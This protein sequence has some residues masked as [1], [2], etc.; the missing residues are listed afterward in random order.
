MG[1]SDFDGMAIASR[2][3][4]EAKASRAT[5]LDLGDLGL[6]ELPRELAELTWL[7][8]LNLA[9]AYF[10]DQENPWAPSSGEG[11]PNAIAALPDWLEEFSALRFLWIT[12]EVRGRGR[13]E[14]LGVLRDRFEERRRRP[15]RSTADDGVSHWASFDGR[16]WVNLQEVA[17]Q[18]RDRNPNVRAS[19]GDLVAAADYF[20]FLDMDGRRR[21]EDGPKQVSLPPPD[22]KIHTEIVTEKTRQQKSAKRNDGPP[23]VFVSH[24]SKDKPF[25]RRLVDELKRR[26]L[27]VW[28]DERE[29]GVGDSIVDGI[30]TGLKESDYLM[31]VLSRNSV[32]SKWVRN[33]LNYALMEEKSRQ[34]IAILPVLIEDCEIPPLLTGRIHADFRGDFEIGLNSLLAVFA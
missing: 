17:A 2:K 8:G 12:L 13:I 3:I 6:T 28:F 27:A 25:V 9:H 30:Q 21:D 14:L 1:K 26:D 7:Q 18:R 22:G 32:A 5:F 20:P 23:K 4:R 29:L 15:D 34:G 19:G 24:S 31:I 11:P 33:E 16:T 10:A